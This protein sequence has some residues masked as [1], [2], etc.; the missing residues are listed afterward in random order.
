MRTICRK[1]IES[2]ESGN[3]LVLVTLIEQ[4][5]SAPRGVGAQMLVDARSTAS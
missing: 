4:E 1:I 5:G 3:S 2:I